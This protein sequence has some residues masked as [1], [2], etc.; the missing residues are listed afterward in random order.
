MKKNEISRRKVIKGGAVGIALFSII[1]RHVM[2]KGCLAPSDQLTKAVVGVGGMGQGHLGKN[3]GTYSANLLAICDVDQAHIDSTLKKTPAGTK[4]YRDFRDVLARDDIDVIHIPTPPHWHGLISIAASNAGKAVFCEKPM[5]RTIGEGEA[6]VEA[7]R[8]NG[9]IFRLNTWFRFTTGAFYKLGRDSTFCRKLVN[10]GILGGPLTCTI[11]A[12]SGF[13]WKLEAWQ[14]NYAQTPQAIPKNLDYDFWLGPRPWRDY[15][16]SHV[17]TNFR[18]Y[19]DYDG[20]GL[21]DMGLH[22]L[23]PAQFILGKDNESPSEITPITDDQHPYIAKPWKK[24]TLKWADGTTIILDG[25]GTAS[26]KYLEGSNGYLQKGGVSNLDVNTAVAA[27]PALPKVIKKF[28]DA[29]KTKQKFALNEVNGHRSTTLVNLAIIAI[30]LN[31][32]LNFDNATQRFINDDEAN[33]MINQPMRAPWT[34]NEMG[35]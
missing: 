33:R 29:I 26:D 34:I 11:G 1:P 17:H 12:K 3:M 8:R 14:G 22:Y 16:K 9:T 27:Q 23:D 18:G 13:D 24:V 35:V 10:S 30:R 5:T 21:G 15:N 6:V 28:G 32:K 2:G 4:G 20:G 31:R 19:W 25:D 7:C